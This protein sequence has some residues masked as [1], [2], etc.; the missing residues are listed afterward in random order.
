MSHGSWFITAL[1]YKYNMLCMC[2]SLLDARLK[3]WQIHGS[4]HVFG[5]TVGFGLNLEAV[6]LPDGPSGWALPVSS[7]EKFLQYLLCVFHSFVLHT[8][9]TSSRNLLASGDMANAALKSMKSL[10]QFL[11]V[12]PTLHPKPYTSHIDGTACSAFCTCCTDIHSA[13]SVA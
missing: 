1:S 3:I 4:E 8:S 7:I 11:T 9:S 13:N 10:E 5:E 12:S 6:P 2:L